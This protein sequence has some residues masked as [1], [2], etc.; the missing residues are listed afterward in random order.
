[1]WVYS[2]RNGVRDLKWKTTLLFIP[3]SGGPFRPHHPT[4]LV[5]VTRLGNVTFASS[6]LLQWLPGSHPSSYPALKHTETAQCSCWAQAK[7]SAEHHITPALLE[8]KCFL[9][10]R[11]IISL[12]CASQTVC[13]HLLALRGGVRLE[14]PVAAKT[15]PS[16]TRKNV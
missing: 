6:S 13:Y 4:F 11:G 5:K 8:L 1:M 14:K 2:R 3:A 10:E 15:F 12:I 9:T 7:V 16:F